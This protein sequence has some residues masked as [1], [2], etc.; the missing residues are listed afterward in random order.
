MKRDEDNT[1][2]RLLFQFKKKIHTYMDL[3]LLIMEKLFLEEIGNCGC[4][5][6]VRTGDRG[7]RRTF[8]CV[9]F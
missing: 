7:R 5:W 2:I 9:P 4:L 8:H 6:G 3:D 1:C